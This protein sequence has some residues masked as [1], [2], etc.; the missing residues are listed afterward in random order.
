[1][2]PY[3]IHFIRAADPDRITTACEI[4]ADRPRGDDK[5]EDHFHNAELGTIE[6]SPGRRWNRVTCS[7]CLTWL[8]DNPD[9]WS[10]GKR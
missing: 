3:R 7:A 1:V 8:R 6:A 2:I 5:R 9:K 4:T 10:D